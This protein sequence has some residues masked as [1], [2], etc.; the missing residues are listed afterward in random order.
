MEWSKKIEHR[1]GER[2]INCLAIYTAKG[3]MKTNIIFLYDP[4]R[5]TQPVFDLITSIEL[6]SHS[7]PE[8]R[9]LYKLI[10][11]GLEFL[12]NFGMLH[13]L[14]QYFTGSREDGAP[15]TIK[16]VKELRDHPPLL[17]FRVNWRGAGA[18]RAV[19]YRGDQF[20]IFP[21]GVLKQ[22]TYDPDFER[23]VKEAEAIYSDFMANQEKYITFL[24]GIENV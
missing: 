24:G 15:Y 11:R 10:I 21:R 9:Q 7:N 2:G 17:E 8:M 22:S 19:L 16:V 1:K 20:L 5:Q 6:E 18:F 23:V 4:D 13:G 14:K 12:E 3:I